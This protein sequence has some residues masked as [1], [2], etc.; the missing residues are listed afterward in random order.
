MASL[1]STLTPDI[2]RKDF[3]RT[4]SYIYTRDP[5]N[6]EFLFALARK[7]P[8]NS[9]V[10]IKGSNTGSAGTKSE[11]CGKW[12]SFGGS[13]DSKSRHM[14]EAAITEIAE[15][16]NI[17]GLRYQ[18]VD[19]SW[20]EGVKKNAFIQLQLVKQIN[21]TVIFLFCVDF[22]NFKRLFPIFP[23]TRGGADIVISSKGEIDLVSSFSFGQLIELQN[24]E[25]T[26]KKNNFV[27]SYVIES[28]NK[29]IKPYIERELS[30][31]FSRHSRLA[32][33]DDKRSRT[34]RP[35]PKYTEISI[36]KYV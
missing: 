20:I 33:V 22:S 10:R 24:K 26:Q 28:F 9:R 25:I 6:G 18:D 31:S 8:E 29:F 1:S 2:F 13:V 7:I 11:Y 4:A 36:G 3:P 5:Q 35:T 21:G 34:I 30:S 32:K 19:I 23:K 27:L 14:L 16:G 15:E 12:G 17:S